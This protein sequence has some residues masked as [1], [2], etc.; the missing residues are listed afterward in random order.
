V[1]DEYNYKHDIG[2]LKARVKAGSEVTFNN[3]SSQIHTFEAVDGSWTTGT[4]LPRQISIMTFDK[5]GTYLYHCKEHPWAYAMLIVTDAN[6]STNTAAPLHAAAPAQGAQGG[7]A[8][9]A[10]RGKDAYQQQC[11]ACH[12]ADLSGSDMIPALAG[13][14]FMARWQGKTAKDM[15]DRTRTTMPSTSPGSLSPQTYM[16][17]VA[18]ILQINGIPQTREISGETLGATTLH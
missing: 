12:Q 10:A 13:S 9:Q 17:L 6:A 14:G 4:L 18:Y 11:S 7:Y 3:N 16:D 5:P 8:T 2:P 1:P 15:F